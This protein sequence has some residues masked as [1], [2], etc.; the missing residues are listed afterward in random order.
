MVYLYFKL[1]SD[2]NFANSSQFWCLWLMQVHL[3]VVEDMVSFLACP[4]KLWCSPIYMVTA[5]LQFRW[6]LQLYL[7]IYGFV[8]C[9]DAPFVVMSVV[10]HLS[11]LEII[12]FVGTLKNY[13]Q[14]SFARFEQYNIMPNLNIVFV[15]S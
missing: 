15:S 8:L 7:A 5:E 6:V 4:T 3:I 1:L 11:W 14:M 10:Y 13:W 12:Q 2:L 9:H